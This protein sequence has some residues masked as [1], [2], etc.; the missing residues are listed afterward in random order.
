MRLVLAL[1]CLDRE[2]VHF[3]ATVRVERENG[4]IMTVT[5]VGSDETEPSQGRIS[6]DSPIGTAL[7]NKTVGDLV[8]VDTPGGEDELEVLSISYPER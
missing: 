5:L 3:G 8:I 2:R 4:K 7:L 1:H 6:T